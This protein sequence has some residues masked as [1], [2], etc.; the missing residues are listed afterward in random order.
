MM[1][2]E[3]WGGQSDG[4]EAAGGHLSWRDSTG[5]YVQAGTLQHSWSESMSHSW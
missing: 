4:A 5:H 2:A 1:N 3:R